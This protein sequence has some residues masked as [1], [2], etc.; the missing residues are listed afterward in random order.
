MKHNWVSKKGG[1]HMP[2]VP[3]LG[4]ANAEE[5]VSSWNEEYIEDREHAFATGT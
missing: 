3:L 5:V 4:S 1:G 2:F